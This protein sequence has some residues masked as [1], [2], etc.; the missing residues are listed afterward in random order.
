MLIFLLKFFKQS[1][2]LVSFCLLL[3]S[4]TIAINSNCLAEEL[5]STEI[6]RQVLKQNV[7]QQEASRI[8]CKD[9]AVR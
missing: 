3:T 8:D 1:K 7:A 2:N 9:K 4:L 6:I 5:S